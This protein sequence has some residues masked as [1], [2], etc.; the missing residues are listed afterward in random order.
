MLV[1]RLRLDKMSLTAP[2]LLPPFHF[3]QLARPLYLCFTSGPGLYPGFS[4]QTWARSFTACFRKPL[5]CR[6]S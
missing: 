2:L 5:T 3:W 4:S 6:A 1:G